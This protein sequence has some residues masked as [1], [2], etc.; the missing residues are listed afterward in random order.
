MEE[1]H[2]NVVTNLESVNEKQPPKARTSITI[3]PIIWERA[4]K[5]SRV[6]STPSNP[7]SF[8]QLVESALEAYMDAGNG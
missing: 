1:N 3:N 8:S 2:L 6:I 7:V 5:Y 4:R